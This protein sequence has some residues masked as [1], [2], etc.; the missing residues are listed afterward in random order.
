M[1][2]PAHRRRMLAAI[3]TVLL[4]P[5]V[6]YAAGSRSS[7]FENHALASFPGLEA[8]WDYLGDVATWTT[9]NIPLREQGV[10][11]NNWIDQT[12]LGDQ[13]GSNSAGHPGGTPGVP[14]VPLTTNGG[15][16]PSVIVGSDGYLYLGADI[17]LKCI[18]TQP[19]AALI[20]GLN[21]IAIAA[22]ASG[23]AFVFAMPPDKSS[24][25]TSN[26]PSTYLGKD[27]AAARSSDVRTAVGSLPFAANLYAP[28]RALSA[29]GTQV[30]RRTDSH[31]CGP[32]VALLTTE[33]LRQV[34]PGV[35]SS[36]DP[37]DGGSQEVVGDLSTLRGAPQRERF[38]VESVASP[39]IDVSG[40][41]VSKFIGSTPVRY[42][43]VGPTGT[44][45]QGSTLILGDSFVDAGGADLLAVFADI[46]KLHYD[47]VND[48][49]G[50]VL[51]LIANSDTVVLEVVERSFA[52]GGLPILQDAVVDQLIATMLA[53][54]RR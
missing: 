15:L 20:A 23:R 37:R 32:A 26:L 45:V 18:A 40:L 53:T 8:G 12:L 16:Y 52:A 3:G 5:A 42:R 19:V 4:L 43:P 10:R 35:V 22:R 6:L 14:G 50:E 41:D 17:E 2:T 11:V 7:Q 13:P 30:Y 25:V 1:P 54:P 46:T 49:L 31:W 47:S 34:A 36:L 24:I 9:D 39:E 33:L 48:E 51:S 27:C 38:E 44:Q 29:S 28:L 21:R